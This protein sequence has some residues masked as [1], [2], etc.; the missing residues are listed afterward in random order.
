MKKSIKLLFWAALAC[1]SLSLAACSDDDPYVDPYET[2]DF[3]NAP[4]DLLAGPTPY[5]D[6]CYEVSY[7]G[8]TPSLF[9]K[10]SEPKSGLTIG[11]VRGM[12]W[13]D[14]EETYEMYNGGTFLSNWNYR[15]NAKAESDGIEV[16]G[17]SWWY[18]FKNQCSVYNIA[19]A[20]G[21]NRGAGHNGSNNFVMVYESTSMRTTGSMTLPEGKERTFN[22]LWVCNSSYTYGNIVEGNAFS[23]VPKL[24]D[25]KGWFK[26]IVKAYRSGAEEPAAQDEIYLADYRTGEGF[27]LDQWTNFD[28]VN[29]KKQA[30]NRIDFH[31][32]GSDVGDFGLNTPTYVCIDD[33]RLLTEQQQ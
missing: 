29:I 20:D 11:L 32:E 15:S 9:T 2:I 31:F 13:T 33:V 28:L 27:C 7:E 23:A 1:G 12:N 30:V 24:K 16:T 6:N 18:G 22:D 25:A 14:F 5:G 8:S 10:W 19:A 26:L 17:D 4:A 21:A 3:E